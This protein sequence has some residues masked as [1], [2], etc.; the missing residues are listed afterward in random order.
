MFVL[1]NLIPKIPFG[2]WVDSGVD[3]LTKHLSGLFDAIQNGGNVVMDTMTNALT[4]PMSINGTYF[5][6]H[7]F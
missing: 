4:A 6:K 1:A 2:P 3:W 5:S 7:S